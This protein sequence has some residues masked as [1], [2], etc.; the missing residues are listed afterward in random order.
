[1]MRLF[2]AGVLA[3]VFCYVLFPRDFAILASRL[4]TTAHAASVSVVQTVKHLS[5]PPR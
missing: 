5:H 3:C 4:E 1:M 2:L